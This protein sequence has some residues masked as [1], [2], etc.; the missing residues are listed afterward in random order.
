MC[1]VLNG[2]RVLR[3]DKPIITLLE[4]IREYCMQRIVNVQK[5]IEKCPGPLTPTAT[6]IMSKIKN[7]A[8][9][10]KVM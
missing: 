10:Y 5:A 6:V 4:Y 9:N 1:E 3:R 8:S 7:V 2:K